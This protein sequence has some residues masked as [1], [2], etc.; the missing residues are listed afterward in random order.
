MTADIVKSNTSTPAEPRL[1]KNYRLVNEILREQGPG[2]H[3]SAADVH[4][5]AQ[6]RQPGIGFTT[7]YRAL[8]RLRTLGLVSEILI[9]GADNAYYETAAL[10]HAHFRCDV[11]GKVDD[12][13]Y[14]LSQRVVDE[15]ASKQNADVTEVSLT[16]HGRCAT[17]R[18]R[19]A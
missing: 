14:V 3:L 7:V 6:E 18:D 11:C 4:S 13:D 19:G 2:S 8:A 10:P 1:A 5:L 16:L 17:C 9:P 15:L 12:I